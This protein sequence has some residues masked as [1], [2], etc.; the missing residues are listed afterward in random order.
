MTQLLW[1][2][3]GL[4]WR[5]LTL[6]ASA[7]PVF[8]TLEGV[9]AALADAAVGQVPG[10]AFR[11]AAAQA[12]SLAEDV[13]LLVVPSLNRDLGVQRGGGQDPWVADF[14]AAL[15]NA[16]PG[17]PP[18][19]AV[20]VNLDL[21]VQS[22][23]VELLQTLLRDPA[24]VRRVWGRLRPGAR[25]PNLPAVTWNLRPGQL[26]TVALVG[27]PWLLNDALVAALAEPGLNLVPL[28][29]LDPLELREEGLRSDARLIDTDAEVLGAARAAARRNAV[30]R[31]KLVVDP[32]AGADAWLARR[33]ERVAHKPVEV[34]SL[35]D[36]LS[37]VDP[38]DT[39]S[40]LQ[41][42]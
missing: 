13:D 16:V 23:A 32:G 21:G 39:L 42:D 9:R 25:P 41:L 38:V 18:L 26:A 36:V 11:L 14:P 6:A 19:V 15:R 33:V 37:N 24:H 27:Q 31:L 3:Y 17:L 30:S 40:N 2:R 22:I 7:T 5:D 10:A 12:R 1:P 4:F 35:P 8:P 29:R 34:L 28:H 20:P